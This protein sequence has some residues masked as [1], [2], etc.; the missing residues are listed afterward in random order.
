[1]VCKSLESVSP[2]KALSIIQDLPL[3]LYPLYYRV[4]PQLSSGESAI[5]KGCM[6]LLKV[7]MLAYR[8]LNVGEVGSVIGLSDQL[9]AIEAWVDRCTSFVKRQGTSVS[10]DLVLF[11]YSL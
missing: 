10:N 2:D 11:D 9:V 1:L 8:P 3:G 5:V 7:I 4:F 6:R